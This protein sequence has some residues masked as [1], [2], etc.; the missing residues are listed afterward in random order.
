MHKPVM[1]LKDEDLGFESKE[2]A[3]EKLSKINEEENVNIPTH[4][5]GAV[6]W[7]NGWALVNPSLISE[8]YLG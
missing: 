8:N 6:K 4:E 5:Y 2:E 3:L 7:E 1:I